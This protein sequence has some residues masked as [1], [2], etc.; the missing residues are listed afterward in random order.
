MA[1]DPNCPVE[2]DADLNEYH[3]TCEGNGQMMIYYCPLCGGRAPKS[4]RSQL[5]HRLTDD[6][7][8]RLLDLTKDLKTVTDVIAALGEPDRRHPVGVVTVTP[9]REGRPETTENLPLLV[10][11]N[12]SDTAEVYVTVH[13]NERVGISLQGKGKK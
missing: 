3:I 8:R 2:F 6:E 9:E 12:L 13:P 7:R 10:Y 4:R 1:D 5:F 11:T